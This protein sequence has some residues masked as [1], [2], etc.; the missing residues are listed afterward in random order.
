MSFGRLVSLIL[1]VVILAVGT[2]FYDL[3]P[4][5]QVGPGL[6]FLRTPVAAL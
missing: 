1:L 2:L 6:F 5:L 4:D 3:S